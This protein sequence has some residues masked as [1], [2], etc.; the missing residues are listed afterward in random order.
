MRQLMYVY[1]GECTREIYQVGCRD[2][3]MCKENKFSLVLDMLGFQG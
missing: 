3:S 1:V 2:G